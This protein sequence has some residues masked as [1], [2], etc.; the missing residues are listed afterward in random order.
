MTSRP[1]PVHS[2]ARIRVHSTR[3]ELGRTTAH[4]T[5]ET[6][7]AG[8]EWEPRLTFSVLGTHLPHLIAD[9]AKLAAAVHDERREATRQRY[10][11]RDAAE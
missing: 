10:E 8:G 4:I 11:A 2:R 5:S 6:L 1:R 3:D 7:R 9:L